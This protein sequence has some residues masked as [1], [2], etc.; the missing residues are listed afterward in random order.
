[1]KSKD[2][3]SKFSLDFPSVPKAQIVSLLESEADVSSKY[4][5]TSRSSTW[6]LVKNN[7]LKKNTVYQYRRVYPI[8]YRLYQM[9][10]YTNLQVM[11]YRCRWLNSLH[12]D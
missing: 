3:Y 1:M 8:N 9:Q 11:L 12:S 6:E 2:L 10:I 7:V 4:Y 5:Y